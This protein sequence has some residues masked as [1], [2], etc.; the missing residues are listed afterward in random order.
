GL[1]HDA[2]DILATTHL[3]DEANDLPRAALEPLRDLLDFRGV[4]SRERYRRAVVEKGLHDRTA[5]PAGSP[6][7][8]GHAAIEGSR[9]S[10]GV[11]PV[12]APSGASARSSPATSSTARPVSVPSIRRR[13]PVSTF[14]GPTS[15]NVR[16]PSRAMRATQS[17]QRTG[18]V[19]C[20]TRKARTSSPRVVS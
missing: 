20:L 3:R 19:I 9:R 11:A 13:S 8:E 5:Y 4:P 10:L 2:V 18:A 15:R 12:S 1:R 14:P 17:V 16:Q 7:D 6:G